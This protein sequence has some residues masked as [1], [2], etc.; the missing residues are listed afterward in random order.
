MVSGFLVAAGSFVVTGPSVAVI[1]F[2]LNVF[3]VDVSVAI[4][5]GVNVLVHNTAVTADIEII[6][7][8]DSFLSF[9]FFFIFI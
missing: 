7:L 9:L 4:E 3:A 2:V 1:S 5:A 6:F 8:S